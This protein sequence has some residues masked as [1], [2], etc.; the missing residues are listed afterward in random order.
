MR[1]TLI[2]QLRHS[3]NIRT[4]AA[5]TSKHSLYP[6]KLSSEQV[7]DKILGVVYGQ[8]LGDAFGLS[9]EF[10]DEATVTKYYGKDTGTI[11]FPCTPKTSHAKRWEI[12]DWTDDTVCILVL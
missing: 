3:Q 12:G 6:S 7:L 8:A 9:T 2:K 11:P 4:Y 1:R 10:M 5:S